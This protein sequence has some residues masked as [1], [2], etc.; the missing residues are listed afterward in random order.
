MTD[1]SKSAEWI[2]DAN[3]EAQAA[4]VA[5]AARSF[6]IFWGSLIMQGVSEVA[7]TSLTQT[8]IAE[9]MRSARFQQAD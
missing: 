7:A 6:A 4:V 8:F 9:T 3:N 2:I 5:N 1:T